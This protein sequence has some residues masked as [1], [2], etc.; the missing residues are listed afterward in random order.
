MKC[1]EISN[2]TLS[3]VTAPLVCGSLSLL[4]FTLLMRCTIISCPGIGTRQPASKMAKRKE[5]EWKTP[6]PQQSF[7]ILS[8]FKSQNGDGCHMTSIRLE[9]DFHQ[10]WVILMMLEPCTCQDVTERTDTLSITDIKSEMKKPQWYKDDTKMI[11]NT[12]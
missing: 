11:R 8:V 1:T 6:L 4:P 10:V 5:S 9:E 12:I 7:K 3:T 2:K